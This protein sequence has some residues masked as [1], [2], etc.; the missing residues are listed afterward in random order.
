VGKQAGAGSLPEAA[1]KT[2]RPWRDLNPQ[3]SD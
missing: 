3:P 2:K 1:G